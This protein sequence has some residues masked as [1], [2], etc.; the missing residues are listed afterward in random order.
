MIDFRL[1]FF[2]PRQLRLCNIQHN[3]GSLGFQIP[4]ITY[5]ALTLEYHTEKKNG[6]FFIN[7]PKNAECIQSALHFLCLSCFLFIPAMCVTPSIC[8]PTPPLGFSYSQQLRCLDHTLAGTLQLPALC[9][10]A[11]SHVRHTI[12]R[13]S[14]WNTEPGIAHCRPHFCS[15][16]I[17]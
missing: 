17:C 8:H 3:T 6:F 13:Q 4:S 1:S 10:C 11:G 12:A 15:I 16:F 9:H 7:R 14:L 2:S 5:S